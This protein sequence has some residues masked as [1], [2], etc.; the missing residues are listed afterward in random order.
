MIVGLDVLRAHERVASESG[1]R[2]S[3]LYWALHKKS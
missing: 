2:V 1:E 3:N